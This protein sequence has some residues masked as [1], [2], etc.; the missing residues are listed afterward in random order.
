MPNDKEKD[1]TSRFS[2]ISK[3]VGKIVNTFNKIISGKKNIKP[4]CRNGREN[5]SKRENCISFFAE[6]LQPAVSFL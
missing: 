2:E 4:E 1:K 5:N 3:Y 6:S